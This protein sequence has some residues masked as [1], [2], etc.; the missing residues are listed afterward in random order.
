MKTLLGYIIRISSIILFLML[1][2]SAINNF[3]YEQH[4]GTDSA[5]L[6]GFYLGTLFG[7]L[8]FSWLLYKLFRFGGKLTKRTKS[9]NEIS[10]IG[11]E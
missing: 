7:F 3:F 1:V 10:E 5:N 2:L 11:Q 6:T 4:E 8:L 9:K